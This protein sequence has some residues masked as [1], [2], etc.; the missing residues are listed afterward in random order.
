MI[1]RITILVMDSVGIGALP[2]SE[3]FGDIGVNTL[4]NISKKMGG[5]NL[6]NLIKLGLGNIDGIEGV[7]SIQNPRGSFG[8]SMEMSNGKDTTTG[9][10][11]I[12]GLYIK[13]PFKTYPD[14]FPEHVISKFEEL[15]GRKVLGNKPASGTEIIKEL[16]EKHIRTGNPI[17]YT[18]ADS[19]FQIAAHEEVIPLDEL[20]KMCKVARE[21]LMGEDQV[22]RV[23]ARPFIG[24]PGDFT[25]TPNRRD[26]SLDPFGKTILDFASEA[27]YEVMAVG[28]I[29]DI[30]NGKGITK[31]IHTKSNMDGVDKTIEFLNTDSKGIIFTNLVDFD[32]KFG[33]RR[34][35][36][37]YKEALE[38]L[39]L[40][41]PEILENLR[42][43]DMLIITADH[44]N[45]PTYKGTDHTREYIPI[46]IYG[47]NVKAGVNIGTRETFADIAATIA[48]ILDIEKPKFGRSFKDLI[49]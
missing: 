39:D 28:K 25:R 34:N 23:I 37:G 30:F 36:K 26:Y 10:W 6:P 20:Y 22:A 11:E 38:E 33:H 32:A 15:I 14:G 7:G 17:V 46:I 27:G 45:D 16:G 48:D 4:G 29:E 31:E 47:K 24:K 1:N 9:H 2:D 35:A 21:I 8:K 18:S 44:G 12:A 43:D 13:E 49:L 41:I 5:I 3:K 40:R 19:V 42:E